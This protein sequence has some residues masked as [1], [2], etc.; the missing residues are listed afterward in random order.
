MEYRRKLVRTISHALGYYFF[1]RLSGLDGKRQK[2]RY[3]RLAKALEEY[4]KKHAPAYV[5]S[6]IDN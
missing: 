6:D 1:A 4:D 3:E 5:G 2:E